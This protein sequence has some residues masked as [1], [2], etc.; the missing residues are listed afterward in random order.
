[1]RSLLFLGRVTFICNLFFIICL[2]LRHTHFTIPIAFHEF[3]IIVGWVLSVLLNFIFVL[4]AVVLHG[5]KTQAL[6]LNWLVVVN[7]LFFLVQI[8]YRFILSF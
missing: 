1:M 7:T 4:A 5:R 6:Q 2:L 3:V 8:I